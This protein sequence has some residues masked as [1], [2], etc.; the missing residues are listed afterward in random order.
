MNFLGIIFGGYKTS[1]DVFNITWP[2]LVAQLISISVT[3]GTYD[4]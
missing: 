1:F 3:L 4:Y 2:N